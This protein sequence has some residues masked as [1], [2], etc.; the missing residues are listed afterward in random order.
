MSLKIVTDSTCDLPP[1]L[2]KELQINVIPLYI[3]IGEK[4]YLDGVEMTR[5]EFYANLPDFTSHPTTGTP[6]LDAFRR[7]YS[8]LASEGASEILSIHISASLSAT[9][10]IAQSAAQ[11]FEQ[12]PV[13][14]RDSRQ[15]S[16]GTGFQVE[17]AARMA[18][19][20]KTMLE[21]L[22]SLDDIADRTLVAARLETLAYLRRSGRMNP[23]MSGLGSLLKVKPILIMK[24]GVP[25]TERVR[26]LPKADARLVEILEQVQPIER[27]AMLHANASE[28][29]AAFLA[30]VSG[31]IPVGEVYSMDITPVIGA[32]IGP[33][34][35]G[36]AVISKKS[37]V[38]K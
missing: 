22:N 13:M 19:D 37:I 33:G 26:T 38:I 4:G 14:V 34:T 24:N 20:G 36:Y 8:K 17:T 2:I 7:V 30:R 11:K 10:N 21:I 6:G 16:L 32:H 23:F 18:L 1:N 31:F 12:V 5:Q 35:L 15:L 25:E 9:V 3:N 29:V 28:K 27:F